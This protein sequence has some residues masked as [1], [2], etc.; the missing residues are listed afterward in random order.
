M[1]IG[2]GSGRGVPALGCCPSRLRIRAARSGCADGKRDSLR[3]LCCG[4]ARMTIGGGSGRGVPALGCCPSRLRNRA[5]RSGCA[6]GKRDSLGAL[7]DCADDH[8]GGSG[9]GVPA[10]G[11]CPSSTVLYRLIRS[12]S[13]VFCRL[14]ARKRSKSPCPPSKAGRFQPKLSQTHVS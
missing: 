4:T 6:D 8:R 13:H 1:T 10:L 5:A 3:G 14:W 2:G 11:C 7:R 9:R 12:R